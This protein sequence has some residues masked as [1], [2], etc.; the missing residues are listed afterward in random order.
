[1]SLIPEQWKFLLHIAKLINKAE[2]L[3]FVLTEGEGWRPAEMQE[4]YVK[5]GRS[6]TMNSKHL[7]RLAHDFNVFKNG[8]LLNSFQDI[9]P[10]GDYW[11]SLDTLNT[12]G[13][14]W[15]HNEIADGFLDCPHFERSVG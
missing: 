4:I 2:E 6:K 7:N 14:D 9:K 11:E 3:G 10:L 12:W 5:T 15:N 8:V 1:M 13:G